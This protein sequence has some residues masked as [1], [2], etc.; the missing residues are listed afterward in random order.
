MTSSS[1]A[2]CTPSCVLAL[3]SGG[4]ERRRGGEVFYLICREYSTLYEVFRTREKMGFFVG[5]FFFFK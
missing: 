5:V 1:K 4:G 3:V 2:C